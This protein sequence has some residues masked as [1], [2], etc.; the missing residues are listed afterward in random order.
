MDAS[1]L[2]RNRLKTPVLI[3]LVLVHVAGALGLWHPE[4]RAVFQLLV[5]F[6]LLLSLGLVLIFHTEWNPAFF[7]F[8][9]LTY[10]LGF[11]VEWAGV[12]TGVIF[13]SYHY[14]HALGFK[15]A[16]V[17]LVI[18]IN[19]VLLIYCSGV[20]GGLFRSNT[21]RSF[22]G[23]LL[24][25]CIDFL[26]EPVAMKYGFWSWKNDAVPLQNYLAWFVFSFVLL[27][28]FFRLK[29]RKINL[30]APLV[31]FLQ[32]L[33]FTMLFLLSWFFPEPGSLF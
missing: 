3:F 2:R 9:I 25:V 20:I 16:E 19:W 7:L 30:I 29:F 21:V 28:I 26:I 18:G 6:S 12:S 22:I 13:G 4:S 10:L 23:A 1:F 5:P 32:L 17:P 27:Q 24:M 8:L 15:Y 31:Y 11:L 14:D 33:F